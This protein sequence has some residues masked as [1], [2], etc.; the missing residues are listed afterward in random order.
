MSLVLDI[1][2]THRVRVACKEFD[3]D[4]SERTL[5]ELFSQYRDNSDLRHVLLK[6]VAVN[7]LYG[8]QIVAVEKVARQIHAN[9]KVIDSG[10]RA[11]SLDVVPRI[12]S[13][14]I[15][16]KVRFNYS[17]ATKYCSWHFP[18]LY[19]IW[20]SMAH[21]YLCT[22]RKQTSFAS[23]RSKDL[24]DYPCFREVIIK[25]RDAFSLAEFSF[26]EID[27]FLWLEGRKLPTPSRVT[28]DSV[29]PS[30]S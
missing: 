9:A 20:D 17:F 29:S 2:N 10:L 25:F 3:E 1:P 28:R 24:W 5:T 23:F 22:L 11:G 18:E 12:A 15:G 27:E 8:T 26:K 13:V 21:R 30:S 6:V 7:S 14:K 19:P 16:E 4:L